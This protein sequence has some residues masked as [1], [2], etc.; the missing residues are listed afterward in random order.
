MTTATGGDFSGAQGGRG[1]ER[2]LITVQTPWL[3]G[4]P[5]GTA[6]ELPGAILLHGG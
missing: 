2:L 5:I 4:S 3:P 1:T 6:E